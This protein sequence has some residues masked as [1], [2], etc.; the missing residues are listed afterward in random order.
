MIVVRATTNITTSLSQLV[1]AWIVAERTNRRLLVQWESLPP[2][3]ITLHPFFDY[4]RHDSKGA[5]EYTPKMH[6]LENNKSLLTY[7]HQRVFTQILQVRQPVTLPYAH[8]QIALWGSASF[9]YM[10]EISRKHWCKLKYV[11]KFKSNSPIGSLDPVVYQAG[12]VPP[13]Q[14]TEVGN[15]EETW[16]NF[17]YLIACNVIVTKSSAFVETVCMMFRGK[18][19]WVVGERG[20]VLEK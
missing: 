6:G 3:L 9:G 4:N 12:V 14:I 20:I 16:A 13:K 8:K 5:V 2:S 7:Y 19:Y 17:L 18:E 1:Q 10:A 15:V 11:Y